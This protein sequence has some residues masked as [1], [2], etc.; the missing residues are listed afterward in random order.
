[1][2]IVPAPNK[3]LMDVEAKFND[4]KLL[5]NHVD[6]FIKLEEAWLKSNIRS[7]DSEDIQK[8][9]QGFEAAIF[10]LKIRIS[11]LSKEGRDK[12]LETHEARIKEITAL[13]PIIISVANKDLKDKHWKKI[14]DKLEQ[15]MIAGKS[16]SLTELLAFGIR[17]KRE[18]IE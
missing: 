12:V 8:E 7:F 18:L 11:N 16:V 5:W 6:K 4:R 17:E 13:M 15:P 14:Y 3:E 10:Q 1:M 9:V 2:E